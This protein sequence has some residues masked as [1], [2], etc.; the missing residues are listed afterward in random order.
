MKGGDVTV[1]ESPYLPA[2][3]VPG[4]TSWIASKYYTRR[5]KF[6]FLEIFIG[7]TIPRP[8]LPHTSTLKPPSATK[9]YSI[10]G[11]SME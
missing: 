4:T 1:A 2:Y 3:P 10:I 11:R 5:N 8:L 6:F 9:F 7:D